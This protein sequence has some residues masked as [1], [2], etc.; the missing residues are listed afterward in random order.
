MLP[1]LFM[2]IEL[3]PPDA[4]RRFEREGAIRCRARVVTV[5]GVERMFAVDAARLGPERDGGRDTVCFVHDE[6]ELTKLRRRIGRAAANVEE[7]RSTDHERQ[8][9]IMSALAADAVTGLDDAQ[10]ALGGL[11]HVP[12]DTR[13]ERVEVARAAVTTTLRTVRTL[14]DALESYT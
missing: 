13:G 11:V 7:H 9:A 3:D 5:G 2:Q 4:R 10:T 14:I 8:V 1:D 6:T 12:A